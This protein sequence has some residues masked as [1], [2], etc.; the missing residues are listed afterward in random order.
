MRWYHY[1]NKEGEENLVN[2]I[3]ITSDE[4]LIDKEKLI[5]EENLLVCQQLYTRRYTLFR[6]FAEFSRF[7]HSCT[8]EEKCFYE[9]MREE[10]GRK[11]YFDIDI[12]DITFNYHSMIEEIKNVIINMIGDKIKILVFES[13]T[14]NK[15][16]F[17]IVLDGVYLQTYK[18]LLIFFDKVREKLKEEY[19]Q[20]IDRSVYK[21]VQQFRILG[22]HKYMKTNTKKLRDYLSYKFSIPKKYSKTEIAKFNFILAS[23]LVTNISSCRVL[24]GFQPAPEEKNILGTGSATEGDLEDVMKLVYKK[25]SYG[26]FEFQECKEKN[27]NLLIVLRRLNCSYCQ[28]CKRSHENENPYVTVIGDYRNVT[29]FCRRNE[30]KEGEALGYLGIPDYTEIMKMEP[31]IISDTPRIKECDEEETPDIGTVDKEEN[32]EEILEDISS[33]VTTIYTPRRKTDYSVL[34]DLHF[35]LNVK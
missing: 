17:H 7:Y 15:L 18:E 13:S 32:L 21:S 25:Y 26:D 33:T 9:M 31:P 29:M 11:P 23:S 10:D 35:S 12:D 2:A 16:S 5:E 34:N 14:E 20:Y 1:F 8:E 28:I 4:N 19:R 24:C 6:N 27:G 30:N 22:S 3:N